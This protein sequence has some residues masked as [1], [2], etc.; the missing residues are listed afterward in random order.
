MNVHTDEEK[1]KAW[2]KVSLTVSEFSNELVDQWNQE[3][4]GLLT[5]VRISCHQQPELNWINLLY[6]LVYSPPS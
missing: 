3:I 4:D 6:R 5:F 2:S 1:R